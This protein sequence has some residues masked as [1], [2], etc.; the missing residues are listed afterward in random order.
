[1]MDRIELIV[2]AVLVV[3]V[4]ALLILWLR[5]QL[6]AKRIAASQKPE[7]KTA[8]TLQVEEQSIQRIQQQTEALFQGVVKDAS[9][10]FHT[11]LEETSKRLNA[12]IVRITTE[13]VERELEEYRQG[14]TQ[15]R[16]E[17]IAALKQMQTAVEQHQKELEAD[18]DSEVAKR[19]QYLI[20]QLDKRL[21]QI[22]SAY[23]VEALGKGADLGAQRGFILQS[24]ELHKE[25][26]KKELK[27]EA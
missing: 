19:R 24:L 2:M 15:A 17:A 21:G 20:E 26:L 6:L 12:L 8:Q 14:L 22:V 10:K 3:Q 25:D 9:Q 11:D 7:V 16:S 18:V 13:V 23:L 1:M 4:A 5:L 27:G